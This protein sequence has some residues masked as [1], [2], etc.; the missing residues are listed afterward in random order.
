MCCELLPWRA[1]AC[2]LQWPPTVGIATNTV[3]YFTGER[4]CIMNGRFGSRWPSV[5]AWVL[6]VLLTGV[7]VMTVFIA[8]TPDVMPVFA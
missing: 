6:A 3:A 1:L 8:T 5:E 4:R 7:V 2:R